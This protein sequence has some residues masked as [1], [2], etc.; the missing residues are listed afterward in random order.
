MRKSMKCYWGK[1]SLPLNFIRIF[2][3]MSRNLRKS[4]IQSGLNRLKILAF[5]V[6]IYLASGIF[7]V[8]SENNSTTEDSS[9]SKRI[10][11]NFQKILSENFQ[12]YRNE[13]IGLKFN[14]PKD[15]KI[16]RYTPEEIKEITMSNDL[17]P[18]DRTVFSLNPKPWVT[19]TEFHDGLIIILAYYQYE[20]Q[21]VDQLLIEISNRDGSDPYES[22]AQKGLL[23]G[24]SVTIENYCCYGGDST[25]Y[26]FFTK[27]NKY[28]VKIEFLSAGPDKDKFDIV[29]DKILTSLEFN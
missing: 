15:M 23:N 27:S 25:T 29:A 26:H 22:T 12:T 8:F 13:E 24:K 4:S 16:Q 3:G 18:I 19:G 9:S 5:L 11:F 6:I 21:V 7:I 17:L 1:F 10:Q 14:Y 28:Y 2:L 20:K